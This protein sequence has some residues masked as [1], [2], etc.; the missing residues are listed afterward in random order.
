MKYSLLDALLSGWSFFAGFIFL[1]VYLFTLP[2]GRAPLDTPEYYLNN[3]GTQNSAITAPVFEDITLKAGITALHTQRGERLNGIHHSLGS[4]ACLFDYDNDGLVDILTLNG[5]GTQHF[6]GRTQ[7]WQSKSNSLSLYRNN[8]GQTFTDKTSAAQLVSSSETMGCNA[9]DLDNDGDIDVFITTRG[10]NQLWQ[11][12]GDGSFSDITKE[13]G[14]EGAR[15]STSSS[16][17][18]SNQDG[19][20]DI[21][22]TNYIDFTPNARVFEENAGFDRE[23]Q[24]KFE[25]RLYQGQANSLYINRG[26]MKFT[27][28]ANQMRVANAQGRGLSA[29]WT[30][31]NNDGWPDLLVANDQDSE[32]K[33]FLNQEGKSFVD[34]STNS[35]LALTTATPALTAVQLNN[36]KNRSIL[37]SARP[38]DHPRLFD[39]SAEGSDKVIA[40]D[41]SEARKL[42]ALG[43]SKAYWG[44]TVQDFNSDGWPD[45]VFSNGSLIPNADSKQVSAGQPNTL[46][47]NDQQG[48]F[49]EKDDQPGRKTYNSLSSRCVTSADFNNDG[50]PDLLF[51]QNND[52]PQLLLNRTS[53]KNWIGF[54]LVNHQNRAISGTFVELKL[55]HITQTLYAGQNQGFLCSGDQRLL[56]G[57]GEHRAIEQ[58]QIGWPDGTKELLGNYQIN[59]YNKVIRNGEVK[60]NTSRVPSTDHTLSATPKSRLRIKNKNYQPQIVEWL[61]ENKHFDKAIHELRLLTG[62]PDSAVRARAYEIAYTLANIQRNAFTQ[63]AITDDNTDIRLTAIQNIK[64]SEDEALIRWLL[65]ALLDDDPRVACEAASAFEHFFREEEAMTVRKYLSLDPL[66]QVAASNNPKIQRC[67]IKAL[68]ESEHYRALDIL[69]TRL[70]NG[71]ETTR[72]EA[73][74]ALGLVKEKS[75]L[76]ALIG[77]LKS[78]TAAPAIRAAAFNS[79]VQ[80]DKQ[81][82]VRSFIAQ[83]LDSADTQQKMNNSLQMLSLLAFAKG[84]SIATLEAQHIPIIVR[85]YTTHRTLFSDEDSLIYFNILSRYPGK[86][87]KRDIAQITILSQSKNPQTRFSAYQLLLALESE[88]TKTKLLIAALGD[89]KISEKIIL[90][91]EN[92]RIDKRGVDKLGVD[93]KAFYSLSHVLN[94]PIR[95]SSLWRLNA[96]NESNNPLALAITTLTHEKVDVELQR[97]VI[98]QMKNRPELFAELCNHPALLNAKLIKGILKDPTGCLAGNQLNKS[99][100]KPLQFALRQPDSETRMAAIKLL[101]SRKENWARKIIRDILSDNTVRLSEKET[102]LKTLP[103]VIP[104]S[105]TNHISKLFKLDTQAPIAALIAKYRAK[106]DLALYVEASFNSLKKHIDGGNEQHAMLFADALIGIM[107]EQVLAHLMH[108]L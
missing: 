28:A 26:K 91:L 48:N 17:G 99:I 105:L 54:D 93:K 15:W 35:Q 44:Q 73:A 2:A 41:I 30:D 81:F 94:E 84:S 33:V 97:H 47:M 72:I 90:E 42:S 103:T 21:Y 43:L 53:T 31:L 64:E 61:I 22:I 27:E 45:I 106:S 70:K 58:V 18:D 83:T 34:I 6:F 68:G 95:L 55:A 56:F 5:S 36:R 89:Q 78:F 24:K 51:T 1:C 39:L 75:S 38:G 59:H 96:Q 49:T 52:L 11:N 79:L 23:D 100:P 102:I 65:Q 104:Q 87:S 8:D 82:D 88:S 3:L 40:K 74:R 71:S 25:A 7:W 101:T 4:G 76:A 60:P 16:V 86:L 20:L 57:L 80:I 19:L 63:S 46:L 85:W 10:E 62:V 77:L 92:L 13:S 50:A 66:I 9:G 32:N 67:A 98:R 12:N 69:I 107:P 29:S 14:I 37:A 108:P